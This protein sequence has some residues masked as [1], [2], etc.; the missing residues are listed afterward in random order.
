M[1]SPFQ[2]NTPDSRISLFLTEQK[3]E[4]LCFPPLLRTPLRCARAC[5]SEEGLLFVPLPGVETPG[6][7][8]SSPAGTPDATGSRPLPLPL[9]PNRQYPANPKK[10]GVTLKFW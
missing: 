8:Q 2:R 7:Y 4:S 1:G 5:G 9:P 10:N 6:Y 3:G